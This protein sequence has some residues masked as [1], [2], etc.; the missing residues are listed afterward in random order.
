MAWIESHQELLN[1]PKTLNL[2]NLMGWNIDTAIGK[3]HR[4]WWWCMD[5]APDGDLRRHN[6][7]QLAAAVGISKNHAERFV[8]AMIQTHW[9]DTEP[10]FR[11]H[12]WWQYIGLF[13]QRKYSRSPL[14]WQHIRNS[15][16]KA[17]TTSKIEL[18]ESCRNTAAVQQEDSSTPPT[19]QLDPCSCTPPN[20]TKPNLTVPDITRQNQQQQHPNSAAAAKC[21]EAACPGRQQ[22]DSTNTRPPIAGILADSAGPGDSGHI[23]PVPAAPGNDLEQIIYDRIGRLIPLSRADL[24]KLFVLK[25]RHGP[26]FFD[27]CDSLHGRVTNAASF[28]T[29]ILEPEQKVA[30]MAARLKELVQAESARSRAQSGGNHG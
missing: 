23:P 21:H 25:D 19:V 28:L 10:Y 3:L 30:K 17:S 11:V 6:A 13:L 27:A 7:P 14:V 16:V 5:Y 15:Y 29:S 12:D 1:H 2:M 24:E 20:L 26:R 22:Q 18:D 9:L 8:S 4:F